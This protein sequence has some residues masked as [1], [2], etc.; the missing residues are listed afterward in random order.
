MIPRLLLN[1][2]RAFLHFYKS[3]SLLGIVW[4]RDTHGIDVLCQPH[5]W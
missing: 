4:F 3:A 1:E 2:I 5:R